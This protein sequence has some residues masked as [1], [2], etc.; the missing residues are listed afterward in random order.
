MR[1]ISAPL[2]AGERL[3]ARQE[4]AKC[5]RRVDGVEKRSTCGP[6]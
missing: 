1:S 6:A 5:S 3:V 4:L 2:E